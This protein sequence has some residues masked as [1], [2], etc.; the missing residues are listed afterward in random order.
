MI[1]EVRAFARS[2]E[3]ALRVHL[4]S[5]LVRI[6]ESDAARAHASIVGQLAAEIGSARQDRRLR[7]I[8]EQLR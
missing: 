7:A 3:T 8:A 4:A 6:G 1:N 2:T 5:A